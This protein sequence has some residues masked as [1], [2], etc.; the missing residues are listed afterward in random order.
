MTWPRGLI[1]ACGSLPGFPGSAPSSREITIDIGKTLA[2]K[3]NEAP[4]KKQLAAGLQHHAVMACLQAARLLYLFTIYLADRYSPQIHLATTMATTQR[5]NLK[6][7]PGVV[8]P[9][10]GIWAPRFFYITS[11][12]DSQGSLK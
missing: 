2:L 8:E 4:C 9:E 10:V 6:G 1:H 12:I 5:L 11:T 3:T 7:C